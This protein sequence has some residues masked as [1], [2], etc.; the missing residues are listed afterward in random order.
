MPVGLKDL[1]QIFPV[2]FKIAK[3][4][5]TY[6]GI[7]VTRKI[8]LLREANY[9]PLLDKLKRNI[10]F[11]RTLPI[12]LIGRINAIKMVFLPQLLYLLQTT[13]LF[14]SKSFFK[15]LD[16]IILPFIWNYKNHRIKQLHLSKPR[17]VGGLAFPDFRCYYWAA[18]LRII[19]IIL[20]DKS[21][22]LDWLRIEK[23]ECTPYN[24]GAVILSPTSC[25]KAC[26]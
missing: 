21:G 17:S 7:V 5:F 19:S 1:S 22:Q 15:Q 13:P 14:L 3:D 6:L 18:N 2:R 4:R 12:S 9:A 24:L 11:W 25:E 16:S 23:D 26:W 20:N 10:Q 8:S